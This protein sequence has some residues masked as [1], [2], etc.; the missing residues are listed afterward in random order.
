M[1]VISRPYSGLKNI[2]IPAAI[3]Q[4]GFLP[5]LKATDTKAVRTVVVHIG[6]ASCVVDSAIVVVAVSC[7]NNASG[8]TL[9]TFRFDHG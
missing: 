8:Q 9:Y 3:Q 5:I 6:V 1:L 4:Q 7:H 2:K